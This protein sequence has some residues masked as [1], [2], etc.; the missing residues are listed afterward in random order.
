MNIKKLNTQDSAIEGKYVAGQW[1]LFLIDSTD[2][3]IAITLPDCTGMEDTVLIL[4][5]KTG[6]NDVTITLTN[7]QTA[8]TLTDMVLTDP[9][10]VV[11]LAP[12]E[13]RYEVVSVTRGRAI[14]GQIAAL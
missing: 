7:G 14:S 10:D 4:K 8:D 6:T 11:I 13:D 3:E 1:N 2:G 12:F 5:L 9:G